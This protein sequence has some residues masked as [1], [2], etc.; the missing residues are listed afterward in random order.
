MPETAPNQCKFLWRVLSKSSEHRIWISY[1]STGGTGTPASKR[2]WELF[3]LLFYKERYCTLYLILIIVNFAICWLLSS[4][5]ISD[6]P[7]WV[8]S[9]ANQYARDHD[10]HRSWSTKV[11]GT[12]W[13]W[14]VLSKGKSFLW[15]AQRISRFLS[16]CISNFR[17][18]VVGMAFAPLGVL[19][20]GK[21]RTDEEEERRKQTGEN[22]RT[23]SS[24][25]WERTNRER[26]SAR[27]FRR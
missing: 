10:S 15:R 5:G 9:W 8:V 23:I 20:S 14:S 2:S 19:A 26:Q 22:D 25:S 4:Q 21:M 16:R 6:T 24:S 7:A 27:P 11:V 17:T 12:S 13:S 18:R 3:I 1:T